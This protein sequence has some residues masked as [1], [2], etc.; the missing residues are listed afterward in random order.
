[1]AEQKDVQVK[2]G[3]TER[4]EGGSTR[5]PQVD[6]YETEAGLTLIAEM[7]GVDSESVVVE[8]EKGVLTISG[9][10]KA[11]E[12]AGFTPLY[13][14]VALGGDFYRAFALSDE[15]D[16]NKTS[17]SLKD[18]LLTVQLPKAEQARTRRIQV[19]AEE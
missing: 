5:A 16:R 17:A 7:P 18:G 12:T 6:I 2:Q 1:M 9:K 8:V 19:R 14:G 3:T 11:P 13:E 10:A 15:I 4:T